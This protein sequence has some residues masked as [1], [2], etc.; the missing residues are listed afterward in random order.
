MRDTQTDFVDRQ[1]NPLLRPWT[2]PHELPPFAA[3]RPEHFAPAFDV[4]MHVHRQELDA[5]ARSPSAP[6]FDNTV[7]AFDWAGRLVRRIEMTFDNLA[8][9]QTSPALQVV[10]LAM[11]QPLAAHAN[12]VYMHDGLFK[13]LDVLHQ[14][15]NTL[16]LN[17]E[18]L[19]LLE[20][21]HLDFVRAGA[22]LQG[23]AQQRFA[24]ISERL[25]QLMTQFGQNVLA[26]ESNWNLPLR[27]EEDFAGLPLALRD[28][29]RQAA[30]E[31]G[32]DGCIVTLSRSMVVPFLTFSQRRD[33]RE[34]AWRAWTS[35]GEHP[36][37]SDNRSLVHEILMLRAE[38][39]QLLGYAN[40]AEYALADSM[41]REQSA[42]EAL[43]SNVWDRAKVAVERERAQLVDAQR[44][45][46]AF[47]QVP[48]PIEPWDWRFW[49][50][51]VR[52]RTYA[53]DDAAVKPFFALERMVTAAFECATRLFGV[54]FHWQ[55]DWPTYHPDVKAY[56]VRDAQ[57]QAVVGVFLHDNFSR[58]GKRSGAWM[59]GY[60]WQSRAHGDVTPIIVNNNNFNKA[61][62]G[63]S[64]LLSFDDVRTL[65]HEFGHGLH[66][67]LSNVQFERLSGTNVLRDYVE[68][69]SQLF[70]HWTMEPDV[71]R[72]HA[73]HIDTN[74]PVPEALLKKLSAAQLFGQAY[75]TVR[76]VASALTDL[77]VHA[78]PLGQ[79]PSDAV[80]FE[81]RVLDEL[82]LP[83]GVGI[84][85][86][87]THFQHLFSGLSYAAG[88]YVY[89]W[90]EVLD[91]DAFSAFEE[92][93]DAFDPA[94]AK[95]LK[96]HVYSAGN[97]V[98]PAAS[99]V[100]FRG[101]APQVEPMLRKRGLLTEA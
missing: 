94:I 99:Y 28:A 1:D 74:E 38:Q 7:K 84:N 81:A 43:L 86:R 95:R 27:S 18:G 89:M 5:I 62:A 6:T 53:V 55:P 76:Y 63:K 47:G 46:L 88:Y 66:G 83:P 70:E 12:A 3:L 11:A 4:G 9:S 19:R 21:V 32:L 61:P 92:A 75:E 24:Q 16:G 23:A 85:H 80:A 60:R 71:L 69:P 20:R 14:A 93:G 2:S 25:A 13:R 65:F 31:R 42:V 72:R 68:L 30:L 15:R 67:L 39:A 49:A 78:L 33:L 48:T 37:A 77:R 22:K 50:E 96:T 59:N 56:E 40:Y 64:T 17:P 41:A 44:A 52:Q 82:A 73:R 36:G 58:P 87:F 90:A 34:T 35:R 45:A 101:R 10:Q 54:T 8:A 29:T 97:S 51:S 57:T 26:D 79:V 100:A 91:A 98:E